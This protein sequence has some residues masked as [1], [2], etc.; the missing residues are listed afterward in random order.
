[1]KRLMIAL[2]ALS[3]VTLGAKEL[4]VL[5]PVR[6]SKK[7][8]RFPGC[9]N[10]YSGTGYSAPQNPTFE[11]LA[12]TWPILLILKN[13]MMK[14]QFDW[15][16]CAVVL[17]SSVTV[18]AQ[19]NFT[20]ADPGDSL[21]S[22]ALNWDNGLP[23]GQQ[24]TISINATVATSVSLSNY[25][26]LHTDGTI[27]Q[28]GTSAVQLTDGA[29]WVT[30]GASATTTTSFRGFDVRSGS[31][32][33]MQNGT[34]N[35]TSGRDWQVVGPDSSMTVNGGVINLGRHLLVSGDNTT[36]PSLTINA[37]TVTS[38]TGDLG[39][40]HFSDLSKTLNLNGGTTSVLN[41]DLQG[42]KTL[43]V[44]GGSTSG[45]LSAGSLL[46]ANV[47]SGFG[48]TSSFNWLPGSLMTLTLTGVDEFAQAYWDTGHLLFNGQSKTDL[49]ELSW[50][51]A[52]NPSIGLGGGYYFVYNSGTE[53]LSLASSGGDVTAPTW[54]ATWPQVDNVGATAF[55]ARARTDENGTAYYVVLADGAAAPNAAEV[56]AGTAAGGGSALA[57][58]SI[59]LTA[60]TENTTAVTGLTEGTAYDVYFVAQDAVPNL[61]ASP[62][63]VDVTTLTAYQDWAD[64][65][66]FGDD[67]NG[68]GVDNGLAFLLGADTPTSSVTL[69]AVSHDSGNLT[70]TFSMRNSANRGLATLIVQHSSDLGIGDLWSTGATMPTNGDGVTFNVTPGSPLDSVTAE[71]SSTEAATGKLFG[72]LKAVPAP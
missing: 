40:R 68:D 71:I 61:Q 13:P 56:K 65:V 55:T 50:A 47:A 11:P 62:S 70:L 37:G 9:G 21:I 66:A 19:T 30:N 60:N 15:I 49:G 4:P 33:T 41:L 51:D 2:S 69:P 53:T 31:S 26:I 58:G 24:G 6:N 44:F 7:L 52:S 1:M 36:P 20:N 5:K 63:K 46:T 35:T 54:T 8:Q 34:I 32:F 18:S 42:D 10:S 22:N 43:F 72:R 45:S 23:V 67:A 64:G 29:S 59:S 57:N 17:A 25:D 12:K 28:T 48:N 39:A 3:I 16:A 38:T 14:N 27:A